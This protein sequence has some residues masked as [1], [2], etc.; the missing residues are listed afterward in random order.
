[1]S[2]P[3]TPQGL[4]TESRRFLPPSPL[5]RRAVRM[6]N[7]IAAINGTQ[8]TQT[9]NQLISE[10]SEFVASVAT[11]QLDAIETE[12]SLQ[13]ANLPG[14]EISVGPQGP[15]GA[16]GPQGA[17]GATGPSG[18]GG[19]GGSSDIVI[20]D[21]TDDLADLTNAV[22]FTR[23]Y[24]S[25]DD[26]GGAI[27]RLESN[28]AATIDNVVYFN[29]SAGGRYVLQHGGTITSLQAGAL[30]SGSDDHARLQA[31]FDACPGLRARISPVA[32]RSV[33]GLV[34]P[35]GTRVL[36]HGATVTCETTGLD[37]AISMRSYSI[38]D[39]G[40]VICDRQSG[41]A[42][43]N[44][45]C[46]F[47]I[48]DYT[49]SPTRTNIAVRNVTVQVLNYAGIGILVTGD[50][51]KILL[52]NITH[53]D[54]A[55][56]DTVITCHWGHVVDGVPASGT[57]HPY[58]IVIRNVDVGELTT[59]SGEGCP[60]TVSACHN[61]LV[62][63]VRS[64]RARYGAE[65]VC[66]DAGYQ[67]SGYT[68][69]NFGSVVFRN[70]TCERAYNAGIR[71][72]N[73][74]S[75]SVI[76]QQEFVFE[77]CT[78]IGSNDGTGQ[79]GIYF[80]TARNC[81]FRNCVFEGFD[82]G[83]IFTGGTENVEFDRT[84]FANN[85]LGGLVVAD[86]TSKNITANVCT[87]QN[88]GAGLSGVS[89]AGVIL[90]AGSLVTL[91]DCIFGDAVSELVQEVG[92]NVVAPFVG[93]TIINC[94]VRATKAAGVLKGFYLGG[95]SDTGQ[96]AMV[97][98]NTAAS[99]ITLYANGGATVWKPGNF[100]NCIFVVG[101]ANFSFT[102]NVT[103]NKL[104]VPASTP[105]TGNR[106]MTLLTAGAVTGQSVTFTRL[107]AGAFTFTFAGK[108]VPA[109]ASATATFDGSAW[110]VTRYGTL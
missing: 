100:P 61:V 14:G 70:I 3:I 105:L 57:K 110:V 34:V 86:T 37:R 44:D 13:I 28:S 17:T 23:G 33:G 26:G 95:T 67:Y 99:G 98:G 84:L 73:I 45:H 10:A 66:G 101:D 60:V 19:G 46:C 7:T 107:D 40:S 2:V 12:L 59:G 8:N 77:A 64:K 65:A 81:T 39:G 25:A 49:N 96:L 82:K 74:A 30:G 6:F 4:L 102:P 41:G 16:T 53:G 97:G 72:V 15:V 78:L 42:S 92:V 38:W 93:A 87:F 71:V 68:L 58:N 1:M 104:I 52:E 109:T 108:A 55:T 63:N 20:V 24:T 89:A 91:R 5:V 29:C 90:S 54:S 94:H 103:G 48:G 106:A 43:G 69:K 62:E 79:S 35:I 85:R 50:S 31:L 22:V 36:A 56:I 11:D 32:Y 83:T 51:H 9:A 75:G 47:L 27:Y 80:E 18:G 76:C 88:N 21:K